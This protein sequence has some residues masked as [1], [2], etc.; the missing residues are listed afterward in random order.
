M[1]RTSAPV[2]LTPLK[3]GALSFRPGRTRLDDVADVEHGDALRPAR[4]REV[5]DVRDDVLLLRVRGRA[6]LGEGAALDD[7]VV[8]QILDDQRAAARIECQISS[9]I[10]SSYR[11]YGSRRGPTFVRIV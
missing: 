1:P 2:S 11:M 8:L 6:R 7:H 9:D 3:S 10:A 4:S 5:G